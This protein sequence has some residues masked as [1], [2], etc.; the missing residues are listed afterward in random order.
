VR[1]SGEARAGVD[2]ER[3]RNPSP[4]PNLMGKAD[5]DS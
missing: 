5:T 4:S 3:D 2:C 1:L